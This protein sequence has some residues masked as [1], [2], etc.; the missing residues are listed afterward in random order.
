MD[1]AY[2][3][4]RMLKTDAKAPRQDGKRKTTEEVH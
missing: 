1:S 3:K 4:Q 2:I